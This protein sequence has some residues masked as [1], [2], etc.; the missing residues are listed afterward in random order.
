MA[1]ITTEDNEI[2]VSEQDLKDHVKSFGR[3]GYDKETQSVK[4]K[5]EISDKLTEAADSSRNSSD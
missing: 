3:P 4:G 5:T 2:L 1:N